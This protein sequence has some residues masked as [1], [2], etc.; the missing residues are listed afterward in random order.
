MGTVSGILE[1]NEKLVSQF[2]AQRF[3]SLKE[4]PD[5]YT[6]KKGLFYSHR[7]FDVFL[8]KLN[9]GEKSAIVSGVNASGTLQLGHKTVFDTNLF[10]QKK[11]GVPVY[12]PISDDES[13]VAKKV[14]TREEAVKNGVKLIIDLIAYGFDLKLTKIV[15]DF[16]FTDIFSIAMNLSRHVTMSEIK[17]VYGYQNEDNI[18]LHF[19]PNVQ[20]AHV[21]FPEINDGIKNTLVPIGPDEDAHLRLGRDIAVRAGYQKP[22]IIHAKFVPG[23]DGLKMSKSRPDSA[24]FLHDT[25]DVIKKKVSKAFSGGKDTIEEH[26]KSGGDPDVDISLMYLSMYFLDEEESSRLREDYKHGKILS[27]ELKKM[28]I[29]KVTEFNKNFEERRKKVTF[30]QVKQVLLHNAYDQHLEE[31]K[32]IFDKIK[33]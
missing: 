10:F 2:Q 4:V 16:Y 15:F 1:D 27:G 14:K 23:I 7:D 28:L 26:R 12:I 6:F 24:I 33:S 20:A 5:F 22:A 25:A 19:Y 8:E 32:N 31:I 11:Y 9:K 17:A 13:Y 3:S 21:L 30:E 29:E 18:G